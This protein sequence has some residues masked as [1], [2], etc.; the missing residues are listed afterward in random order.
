[1]ARMAYAELLKAQTTPTVGEFTT[2]MVKDVL[3]GQLL[4]VHA[5]KTGAAT[6]TVN[7]DK[8]IQ[9]LAHAWTKD[10]ATTTFNVTSDVTN[11][12]TRTRYGDWNTVFA[13]VRPDMQDRQ[14]TSIKGGD[15]D[16]RITKLEWDYP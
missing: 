5:Q 8:R 13:A 7:M 12:A 10:G 3:P 4:H 1:M 15:M 9:K 11:S 14:A 2:S 6:F 16:I